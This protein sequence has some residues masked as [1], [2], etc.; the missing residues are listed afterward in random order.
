MPSLSLTSLD[1][2]PEVVEGVDLA[3]L[4]AE[5]LR[6]NGVG[7][8]GPT[9]L[10]VSSK[11]VS[12]ALGLRSAEPRDDV[13]A[14]Q[15]RRV[16]AERWTGERSTR[17]VEALAGP[18]MAAAGV[19]AS[20]TGAS[21]DLLILPADPD[22]AARALRENLI[23]H[24]GLDD[25]SP[26]GVVISDTAGRPWRAG[27]I[28]FALGSAGVKPMIDHRG[29]TDHDGR[30][31]SVTS[32]CLVDE[33]ASM[34]DLVKG[35]SDG[36][37]VAMVRGCPPEW[38]DHEAP[39]AA[40]VIRTGRGDWFALGHVE[41][42]RAAL[43]IE[44]G[45]SAAQEVGVRGL[46]PEPLVD[47]ARRAVRAASHLESFRAEPTAA[48]EAEVSANGSCIVLL[49]PEAYAAGRAVARLE[50]ALWGEDVVVSG[51]HVDAAGKADPAVVRVELRIADRFTVGAD[52]SAASCA[53]HDEDAS[54]PPQ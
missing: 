14:A 43:G 30:P 20:N 5:S 17:I 26:L 51:Q 29:R 40:S 23:R 11:V 8:D 12:K 13:I 54:P 42:V 21:E 25:E 50:V 33:L 10:V 6:A 3:L 39:G 18:I 48:A 38:F 45:S 16:V 9:L 24:F 28:D 19:D 27:Q 15:S 53:A 2:L 35:K 22:G 34:A 37:P 41:A 52:G 31:L 46:T 36:V 4:I 1:G 7:V 32:R 49:A 47:R 44:P